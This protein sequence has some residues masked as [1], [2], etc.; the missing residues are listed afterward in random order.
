[1]RELGVEARF[2]GQLASKEAR[3]LHDL[4]RWDEAAGVIDRTIEA[5]TTH[6]AMRWLLSNRIRLATARGDAAA[7]TSDLTTY[8]ALGQRVVGPDPD[9]INVRR[10]ELAILTGRPVEAR[11][12]VRSTLD[13]MAE[14][15][16]D[17][18][19][20]VLMLL[21]LRAE[22]VEADAGRAAGDRKRVAV[23]VAT[24]DRLHDELAAHLARVR[25]LA[26]NP[27]P[28]VVADE[29]L[30]RALRARTHGR[31]DVA[32]W[33]AAVEAR[34]P[35]E[36]PH[37][38][39]VVL[40]DA[41][42]AHL[43]ARHREDGAAALSEAHAIAVDLRATPLRGRVEA[44]ARRARIGIEGVDTADDAADRL[45]L[46]R[47]EREVLALLIDGRSNRQIGEELFMAESTAGVHVSNILAKLGVARRSEA[48]AKAHRLG[49]P[50]V[51]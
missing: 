37:E 10:A 9:L 15:S 32:A 48:M 5:G 43:A 18:D 29:L 16:L 6:Y 46:T 8:E 4:G 12:L 45:G 33:D 36:R 38:L 13:D 24:A 19:A 51:S 14:P 26:P 25:E 1:M 47:R 21:G 39:A 7:A 50:G 31:E 42:V 35:L 34:R 17:T 27:V 2:G 22:A 44:L 40:A 20:R 30:A 41:A 23:A 3:A 49:L 28:V 11:A